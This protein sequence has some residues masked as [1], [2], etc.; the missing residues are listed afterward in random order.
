[1]DAMVQGQSFDD[2]CAEDHHDTE[3]FEKRMLFGLNI[4]VY[5]CPSSRDLTILK[6]GRVII[7]HCADMRRRATRSAERSDSVQLDGGHRKYDLS[8]DVDIKQILDTCTYVRSI[9]AL[10]HD[11]DWTILSERMCM[12]DVV[13][14]HEVHA[15]LQWDIL[16]VIF[17][18]QTY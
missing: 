3:V 6:H 4:N 5:I 17:L 2:Y 14:Y 1:M 7:Y 10:K 16:S 15:P 18:C 13:A 12:K 11:W 8:L 9:V